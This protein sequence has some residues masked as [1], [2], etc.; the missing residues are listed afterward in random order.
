MELDLGP[1]NVRGLVEESLMMFKEKA[2][3]HG[4]TVEY[5]V[6]DDVPDVAADE[7]KLKQVLVN[8]LSNAFKYTPDNG[9]VHVH[10][11]KVRSSEFRVGSGVESSESGV[12]SR[13][14]ERIYSELINQHS[15]LDCDFM[16]IS[17]EDTGPGIKAEDIPRLFQPFQQ[18]ETTLTKKVPGTGLGLNLCKK[19][20]ELHGGGI[21][22]ESE[23]GKGSRFI[24]TIPLTTRA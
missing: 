8:L 23:M 4:T 5:Q 20:V 22:V 21:W 24:F 6:D 18:L 2:M 3:K 16:E 11:R 13:E 7:M 17:V 12:R 14:K 19:F 9:S 15:E 1:M 10:A